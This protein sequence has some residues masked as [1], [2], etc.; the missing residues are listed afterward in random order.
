MVVNLPLLRRFLL[1]SYDRMVPF[2]FLLSCIVY[3]AEHLHPHTEKKSSHW[4]N[5]G[6]GYCSF[7]RISLAHLHLFFLWQDTPALVQAM[8]F[9][10]APPSLCFRSL[11]YS[12]SYRM[13]SV[14]ELIRVQHLLRLD[15]IVVLLTCW[16]ESVDEAIGGLLFIHYLT[17]KKWL[18]QCAH[19]ILYSVKVW[20]TYEKSSLC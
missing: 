18:H 4:P 13:H 16:R 12:N 17:G 5:T 8:L 7:C 9:A 11:I 19:N 3:I 6:G 2:M 1:A 20:H 15:F 10:A 14:D